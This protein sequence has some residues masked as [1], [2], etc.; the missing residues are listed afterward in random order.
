MNVSARF[1]RWWLCLWW[2]VFL[3]SPGSFAITL[4]EAMQ[5]IEHPEQHPDEL[6]E[7]ITLCRE[8]YPARIGVQ[9]ELA[10]IY[11]KLEEGQIN[12]PRGLIRREILEVFNNHFAGSGDVIDV[13]STPSPN[14]TKERYLLLL[15]LNDKRFMAER[16]L[17][18]VAHVLPLPPLL[19]ATLIEHIELVPWNT[20]L[21]IRSLRSTLEEAAKNPRLA[22]EIAAKTGSNPELARQILH[23]GTL[24]FLKALAPYRQLV[25][26][27]ELAKRLREV[28]PTKTWQDYLAALADFCRP[29]K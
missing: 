28:A 25:A 11:L 26:H 27:P 9:M 13:L 7:A 3:S 10:K 8:T 2:L 24:D 18:V 14:L 16:K 22:A 4:T 15:Q 20:T 23:Y 17:P 6:V 29:W 21:F 1:P 5:I 19:P 12:D